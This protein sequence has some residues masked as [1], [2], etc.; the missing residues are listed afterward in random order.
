MKITACLCWYDE[1]VELLMACVAS[2]GGLADDLV[3][4]DG[5]WNHFPGRSVRSPE[6]QADAIR[7][8]CSAV[9]LN[10]VI[11][12]HNS[13]PFPSQVAKRQ[14]LIDIARVRGA[15]WVLVVDAD[16]HALAHDRDAL[17]RALLETDCDVAE[18][19]LTNLAREWPLNEL[20]IHTYRTR[21]LFRAAAQPRY[22]LA[23][24]G[25]RSAA[26]EWLN[27]DPRHVDLAP[28][29]DVTAALT[30]GH[31]CD[32]RPKERQQRRIAYYRA[33]NAAQLE[34]WTVA[35]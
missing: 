30:L 21:R 34:D 23:H 7:A 24:N 25:V 15:D 19:D 13:R 8:A 12:R 2:L 1:P 14:M 27:G 33:R 11:G 5:R 10:G 26:D 6:D 9:A 3:A 22:E 31:A 32:A 17:E 18:L 29:A 16:E 28:A 35:A 4:L 20:P